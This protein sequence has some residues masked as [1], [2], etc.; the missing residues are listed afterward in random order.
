MGTKES[1]NRR[2][3]TVCVSVAKGNEVKLKYQGKYRRERD[4]GG[5]K[6]KKNGER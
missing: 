2:R 6:R 1:D 4:R 3:E 5:G